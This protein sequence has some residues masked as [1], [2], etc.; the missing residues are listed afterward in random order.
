MPDPFHH[1]ATDLN[2]GDLPAPL[3]AVLRRSFL[4][5]MGV[6]AV[7]STTQMAQIALRGACAMFGPTE[8]GRARALMQ[9]TPLSPAG[10]AMAGGFTIDAVD[11]HDSS[12][13]C[14]GHAGSAV[15][16]ALMAVADSLPKPLTGQDFA[17][18]LALGYEVSYRAGLA[19]HATCADY[20]TSGAWTS[21]GVATAVARALGC[22][23]EAIRHAAGIGEYHGPRSQMM[24]CIDHPTM[25]RDGVGWGAPSGVVAAYLAREGFTGAPALTCEEAPTFWADLGTAW[26]T[27]EDT[28]YKPYP[29]CRWAHPSIDS[30]AHLMATHGLTHQDVA[31]VDIRT[32]H[33]ATRLAGHRPASPDEFAYGIA[34]P[35][36]TMI[37]RGQIGMPELGVTTL[38]DPDILRISDSVRL[39]DDPHLTKI[40]QGK[41]WAQVTLH[42]TDG[43][44]FEDVARTPKGDNDQPLSDREISEKFHLFADPVLGTARSAEIE[45]LC[46]GFDRL[47]APEFARLLDLCLSAPPRQ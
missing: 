13:P 21:V 22:D 17:V 27:V 43:R 35:V 38:N 34:F 3:L 39:I 7:A 28:S 4:D 32:F 42:T 9:G 10:A 40:S 33:N 26:R 24:R 19:Q 25:V 20:H 36:A 18:L 6:A 46:T 2:Y 12:S 45:T 5:T 44:R 1:F 11:A 16:P 31:G 15:F 8:A 23:A 30:V 41:R 47:T 14:K 37:V 29:C